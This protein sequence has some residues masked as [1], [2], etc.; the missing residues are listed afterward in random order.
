MKRWITSLLLFGMLGASPAGVSAASDPKV[1]VVVP[2]DAEKAYTIAGDIFSSYWKQVTGSDN[3]E[4]VSV[5]LGDYKLPSAENIVFIG[6]DAV[7]AGVHAL[8]SDSV[9]EDLGIRYGVDDY[10]LLSLS[11]QGRNILIIAGGSGRSTIFATYDFFRRR[12]GVDYFWDGDIFHKQKADVSI[13]GLDVMEK[14]RFQ[15]RGLRYFAHRGLHRFEAEQWD[16]DDWTREIDWIL[17]SRMNFFMVRTGL[18]DLFQRA[19][20]DVNYPPLNG[21]DPDAIPR[22]YNDRTSFWPLRYRGEL[23]KRVLEYARNR[24]LLYPEDAGTV[25]HWYSHTPSSFYKQRPGFPVIKDQRTGYTLRS[26]AIWDVQSQVS[27]DAY[28]KLTE[29]A[30]KDFSDDAYPRLFHTIGMAERTFGSSHRENIQEKLFVYRKTNQIIRQHYPDVPILIAGW[31]LAGW[32]WGNDDVKKLLGEFDPAKTILLDYTDDMSGRETYRDFGSYKAFPWI[33]GILNSLNKNSDIHGDY[34]IY[35]KRIKEAAEDEKCIGLVLWAEL[36]HYNTFLLQ[37]LAW[38]SWNPSTLTAQQ[39]I[40][41]YC[42]NRYPDDI[43]GDMRAVWSEFLPVSEEVNF[44]DNAGNIW[45]EP[46]FRV[47]TSRTFTDFSKGNTDGLRKMLEDRGSRLDSACE[48]LIKLAGL[49]PGFSTDEFWLRDALDIARTVGS[50]ALYRSLCLSAIKIGERR[51]GRPDDGSL[52]VLEDCSKRILAEL[53]DILAL[54]DDFS[55]Y[56]GY[57][58]LFRAEEIAGISPDVNSYT[59]KTLK[60]NAENDYCRTE[61]YELSEYVYRKELDLYWDRVRQILRGSGGNGAFA[62]DSLLKAHNRIIDA[63]YD[64]P[65]KAMQPTRARNAKALSESL[66]GLRNQIMKLNGVLLKS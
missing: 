32:E 51:Q 62:T 30:I 7:N 28:W 26:A 31:D 17:K 56:A 40:D 5:T 48:S 45:N 6:S 23:R 13:R 60:G 2:G 15:Y 3:V 25:T 37:Y 19:F 21:P 50:R 9:I 39:A 18:D 41:R 11:G 35:Q 38:N 14:P 36:S 55:M 53:S 43:Q 54:S 42:S 27:W 63:F 10:R 65:L 64:M 58:R 29:T 52:R 4:I 22:S 8:I 47:L 61:E 59:E 34:G 33:F 46:Q 24:G 12:G 66:L 1:V 20:P 49:A 16:Y 44:G 57:Q